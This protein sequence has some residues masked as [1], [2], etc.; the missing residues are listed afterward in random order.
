[1]MGSSSLEGK[2]CHVVHV[3]GSLRTGGAEKMLVNLLQAADKTDFRYTV[4]CLSTAGELAPLLDE[5]GVPVKVYKV[6]LRNFVRD[7]FYLARWFKEE[8][9]K[10]I[11]SHM[12]YAT[13]WS[14]IA[15]M[16]AGISLRITTEHGKE[17]WKNRVQLA[18]GRWLSR[19]TYCHIAVSEDIKYIRE[20]QQGIDSDKVVVIP[21]G[22][23]IPDTEDRAGAKDRAHNEFHLRSDQP[24]IGTV[25]RVVEAKDYPLM[26]QAMVRVLKAIPDAHWLQIGDGPLEDQLKQEV[27][28]RGI[29]ESVTFAGR[30]SDIS[31][32]LRAMDVWVMSSVREGLPVS[33]LEAMAE[34]VPI[35]ATEVGGIPDAV[36]PNESAV[37]VAAG[38]PDALAE[39]MIKVLSEPDFAGQLSR[40]AYE[41][42]VRDYSIQAVAEKVANIYRA[43]LKETGSQ[44][45]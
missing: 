35:V 45:G 7:I 34:K 19:K 42:V 26:A 30:R 16:V 22:V 41:R 1:M 38:D 20:T 23:P 29:S 17:L 11:H 33:L 43:G 2:P 3:I 27:S 18:L 15:A 28:A 21:N 13:L 25:G 44:S 39:G 4:L 10:V 24:V 32:L 12:F 40:N 9:V 36:T 37:L 14:H 8:Q 5:S 31:L 6:R